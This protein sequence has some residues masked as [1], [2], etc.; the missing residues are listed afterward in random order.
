MVC[1]TQQVE[2]ISLARF[3]GATP[4]L[5]KARRKSGQ[6]PQ[7][8]QQ[9]ACKRHVECME[10]ASCRMNAA[11][12]VQSAHSNA[13]SKA[14][15]NAC[16]N[17]HSNSRSN[18]RCIACSNAR[19]NSRCI[20]C[21]DAHSNSRKSLLKQGAPRTPDFVGANPVSN[22]DS[23]AIELPMMPPTCRGE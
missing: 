7:Q 4:G 6:C 12:V 14:H 17:T 9:N 3:A 16:S 19:R 23:T 21:S 18:S 2:M 13:C 15:S 11:I 22:M 20:A 5:V 1:C 8:L 10:Q